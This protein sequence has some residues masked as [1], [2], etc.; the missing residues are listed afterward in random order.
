MHSDE[1]SDEMG[2]FRLLQPPLKDKV[3]D[4]SV[5]EISD[6][7]FDRITQAGEILS[8]P[9]QHSVNNSDGDL[10][11]GF[12]ELDEKVKGLSACLHNLR[13]IG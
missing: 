2:E 4:A 8:F 11:S 7:G 1:E 13:M 9:C 3:F 6:Q 12:Q 10:I 5:L